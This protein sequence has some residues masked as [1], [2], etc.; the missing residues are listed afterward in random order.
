MIHTKKDLD[1][2]DLLAIQAGSEQGAA[3]LANAGQTGDDGEVATQLTNAQCLCMAYELMRD[4]LCEFAKVTSP[5]STLSDDVIKP[6]AEAQA[7]VLDKYGINLQSMGGDYML[8]IK[9]AIVTVPVLLAF[10]AGL[11]DEMKAAKKETEA[12]VAVASA[13]K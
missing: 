4:T 12:V 9:A 1:P 13:Q 5:K 3:D 6:M 7:K 11:Q 10:R 2:L 8:E